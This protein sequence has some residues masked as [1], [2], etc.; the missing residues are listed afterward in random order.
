MFALE[1][2]CMAKPVVCNLRQDLV[3]LYVGSGLLSSHEE[4]PFINGNIFN[5]KQILIN[6][7]D[8]KINLSVRPQSP[9][10]LAHRKHLRWFTEGPL[11][12][13]LHRL[14]RIFGIGLHSRV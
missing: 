12:S 5:I 7:L 13:D 11:C 14:R 9:M 6:I 8:G 2:L 3:D 10:P 4:V 1:S